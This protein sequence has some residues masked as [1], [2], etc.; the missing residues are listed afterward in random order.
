MHLTLIY[1]AILSYRI[2]LLPLSS[3]FSRYRSVYHK[4][5]AGLLWNTEVVLSCIARSIQKYPSSSSSW[6][7]SLR[8]TGL[9]SLPSRKREKR[10]IQLRFTFF[11]VFYEE[12]DYSMD[13]PLDELKCLHWQ[14]GSISS[15]QQSRNFWLAW[16]WVTIPSSGLHLQL[17]QSN[18]V[19]IFHR[20]YPIVYSMLTSR[21]QS[22]WSI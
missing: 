15:V 22:W 5:H 21:I 10:C 13:H 14:D 3:S 19:W 2:H 9:Q 12:Q 7:I 17:E 18:H 20:F 6:R 11:F 8:L 1:I 4:E 16:P